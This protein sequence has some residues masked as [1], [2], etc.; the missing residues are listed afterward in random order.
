[1]NSALLHALYAGVPLGTFAILAALIYARKDKSRPQT[2]Q[3]SQPWTYG[4]VLW[5]AVDER[6]PGGAHGAHGSAST[7][8]GGAS[9]RW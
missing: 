1:M 8:G 2:Y 6:I 5:S 4:P 9:G 7:V 3:L